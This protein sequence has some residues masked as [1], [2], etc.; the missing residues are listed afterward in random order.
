MKYIIRTIKKPV[1]H[2]SAFDLK[3]DKELKP[4][5]IFYESGYTKNQM[6]RKV[7]EDMLIPNQVQLVVTD[8]EYNE[9]VYRMSVDDFIKNAEGISNEANKIH[10]EEF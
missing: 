3:G 5:T 10:P 9:A 4:L 6:L 1:Y 8:V 2:I 7:R